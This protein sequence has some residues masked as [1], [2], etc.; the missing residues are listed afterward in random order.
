[1]KR[2][3]KPK[4]KPIPK[5]LALWEKLTPEMRTRLTKLMHST[6]G[7]V[8]QYVEGRRTISAGMAIRMEKA[9]ETLDVD[10]LNRRD[11]SQTC[12]DC[13]YAIACTTKQKGDAT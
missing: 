7:T 1:M 10:R 9:T 12:H 8:R 11:L 2:K 3:P 13:E 5:L 6:P 4:P